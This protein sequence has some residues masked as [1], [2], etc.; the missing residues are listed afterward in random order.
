MARRFFAEPETLSH[1]RIAIE[2][3]LAHR[4]LR[5]LR[6]GEGDE[7]VLFDGT[8]MDVRVRL[9]DVR[10]RHAT[11][12]VLDRVEGPPEP[13]VRVHLYQ[14]I[15]KGE[16]FEWLL[17]KGTEIGVATF[18]PLVTARSVVKTGGGG[19][20]VERWRRIVTEAAEQSGRSAVPEVREPET[21]EQSLAEAPGLLLLPYEAAGDAAPNI[22][23]A[24][25]REIDALFALGEVSLF[26]GPEGGFEPQEVAAAVAR[27]ATVV[28][29]G[30]RVLR[31]ETAGLVAATLTMHAVGELG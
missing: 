19:N 1:D 15:A 26:V 12:Q 11:A 30:E 6:L 21:F 10:D 24:L 3:A 9:D 2:G 31:S 14:A 27:G 29:M 25:D 28:T 23:A 5:V 17:E 7:F 4:L 8:G 13:H 20:R 22:Q 18:I 16:R